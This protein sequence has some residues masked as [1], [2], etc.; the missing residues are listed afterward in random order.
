[1]NNN[2]IA[3]ILQTALG[4]AADTT[5]QRFHVAGEFELTMH[6]NDQGSPWGPL[7]A[8]PDPTSQTKEN[9]GYGAHSHSVPEV[10][11]G[12]AQVNQHHQLTEKTR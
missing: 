4:H 12:A 9:W 6:Q 7:R 2:D 5:V 11:A 3:R 10:P 8:H 1:M